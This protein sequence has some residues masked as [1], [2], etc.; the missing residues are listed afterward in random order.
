M[1][2]RVATSGIAPLGIS[3]NGRYFVD[4]KAQ[5]FFWLGDTLWHLYRSFSPAD[6]RA[7]LTSR[8]ERGFSAVLVMLIGYEADPAP[9][10]NGDRPWLG[11]DPSRPNER[12]F[13]HVDTVMRIACE[14]DLI[15]VLGV[16][17]KTQDRFYDPGRARASARWIA[18]RY[19]DVPQIIWSMYPEAKR[20]Y[21][22]VVR[23]IAQG[24][25]EGDGGA[26]WITV[27]PD[28]SPQSSSFLHQESWLPF[29]ML[30][31]CTDIEQVHAMTAADYAFTPVKPVVMAEGGYEGVEFGRLI[32]PVDI[33]RQAYWTYLAGGHHVNGHTE[34]F[35]APDKWETWIDSPGSLHLGIFRDIITSLERWWDVIPNQS[36]FAKGVGSGAGLNAAA[37]SAAAD[38][39]LA[40]LSDQCTVSI[41]MDRIKASDRVRAS[42]TDPS[43]GERR[44]IGM[45]QYA[46]VEEFATPDGWEDALLLLEAD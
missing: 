23:A 14:L 7:I 3:S 12:Y 15:Q 26:H 27:H 2:P 16:Y 46:D 4:K 41:R 11:S 17:H 37:H 44:P 36:I 34:N 31:T 40:Y 10:I 43:S 22:P 19:R 45:F 5:P 18:S 20:Q 25:A 28:P 1:E 33:R 29:N 38:W 21:L 8:K 9:N 35:V 30:Q 42:W 6:V 32:A 13:E 24:L 39:A